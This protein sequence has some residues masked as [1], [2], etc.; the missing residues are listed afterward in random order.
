MRTP[1]GDLPV[2]DGHVHFFSHRFFQTLVAQSSELP[3]LQAKTGRILPPVDPTRLAERWATEMNGHGV[4][5]ASIIAS[6]PADESPVLAVADAYR[7]QFRA[8]AEV[9]PTDPNSAV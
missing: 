9:D 3:G 2:N 6:G 7:N 8:Y 5:R 1:W 4:G